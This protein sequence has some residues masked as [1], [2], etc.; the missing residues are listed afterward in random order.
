MDCFPYVAYLFFVT[1][2][3]GFTQLLVT[4]MTWP[5]VNFL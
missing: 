1:P 5:L 4:L 2:K 3:T